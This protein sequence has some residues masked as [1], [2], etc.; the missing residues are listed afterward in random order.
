MSHSKDNVGSNDE[1]IPMTNNDD[2]TKPVEP[3]APHF[4]AMALLPFGRDPFAEISPEAML[5]VRMHRG[6]VELTPNGYPK[7]M[8]TPEEIVAFARIV[9][10]DDPTMPDA[11]RAMAD[12]L[13]A[14]MADIAFE[15]ENGATYHIVYW[16]EAGLTIAV[17]GNPSDKESWAKA[18]NVGI[19]MAWTS[20]VMPFLRKEKG[21]EL[22]R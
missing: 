6:A 4:R 7:T 2:K 9:K 1:R 20:S 3:L 17:Y 22:Y 8:P 5:P 12:W 13:K 21:Y 11:L 15:Q 16:P 18:L 19:S 10:A 14:E